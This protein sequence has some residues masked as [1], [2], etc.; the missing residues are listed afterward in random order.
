VIEGNAKAAPN[1][2]TLPGKLSD[3][4]RDLFQLAHLMDA[5]SQQLIDEVTLGPVIEAISGRSSLGFLLLK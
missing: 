2:L 4:F 5:H 3:R 1:Y